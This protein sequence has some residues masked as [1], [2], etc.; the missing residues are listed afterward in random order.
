MPLDKPASIGKSLVRGQ[1]RVLWRPWCRLFGHL[2]IWCMIEPK[3]RF[4]YQ[5]CWRCGDTLRAGVAKHLVVFGPED[6]EAML[7]LPTRKD[8]K[9]L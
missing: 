1:W 8:D 5:A 3:D 2:T 9:F 4:M 6:T 7:R